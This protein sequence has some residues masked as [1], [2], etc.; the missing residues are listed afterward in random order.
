MVKKEGT[1]EKPQKGATVKVHYTGRLLDG[2]KFDSSV[3]RG[4]PIEFQV[5]KRQVIAGWDQALQ[6][7]KKGEKRVLIIPP[8]LGYGSAG[9]GPIPPDSW[10]VFDVEL[11]DFK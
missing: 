1:G 4:E 5:G 2:T 11:L 9:V 10:L 6:H 7:M 8:E 3:D